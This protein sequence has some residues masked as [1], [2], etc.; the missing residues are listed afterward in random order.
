[1]VDLKKELQEVHGTES[2]RIKG[3]LKHQ[4]ISMLISKRREQ[5]TILSQKSSKHATKKD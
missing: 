4:L 5:D 3:L 2:S 1:V